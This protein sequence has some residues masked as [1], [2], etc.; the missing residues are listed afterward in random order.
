MISFL[1]S[2]FKC[3]FCILVIVVYFCIHCGGA[4]TAFLVWIL[5]FHCHLDLRAVFPRKLKQTNLVT[6]VVI[7]LMLCPPKRLCA[8]AAISEVLK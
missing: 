3:F 5:P 7:Y 1:V 2:I 4:V 6:M 8:G